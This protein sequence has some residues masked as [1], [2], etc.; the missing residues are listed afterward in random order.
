L[1]KPSRN[2]IKMEMVGSISTISEVSTRQTNI[3][4]SNQERK[5]KI[6]FYKNS[7]KLLK[8]LMP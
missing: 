1:L 4:M 6:K 5:Q 8:P 2:L 3:Q 7:L